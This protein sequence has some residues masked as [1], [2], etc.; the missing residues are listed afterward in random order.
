MIPIMD[1]PPNEKSFDIEVKGET[2]G[3]IWKGKFSTVCVPTCRQKADA[4]VLQTKLNQ[5][6]ATLDLFIKA[7]HNMIAQ[8]TVRL[9]SAPQ[10]WISADNGQD[11]KDFNVIIVVYNECL[12]A[13]NEWLTRVW[14][15]PA[16][17]EVKK[18]ETS[19]EKK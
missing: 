15:E 14:G 7:Y 9:T 10:W 2:S 4:F 12:K 5:D 6:L 8:L 17:E 16:K 19:D 1:L 13:E 11:L 3:Q 18:I